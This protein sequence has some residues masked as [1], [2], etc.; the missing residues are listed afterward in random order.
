MLLVK[1]HLLPLQAAAESPTFGEE[2]LEAK[3][4]DASLERT[5]M[6][7]TQMVTDFDSIR[8]ETELKN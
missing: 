6:I 2:K 7:R 8:R 3:L 4:W 1:G 5:Q